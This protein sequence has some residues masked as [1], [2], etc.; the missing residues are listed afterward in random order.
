MDNNQQYLVYGPKQE[1]RIRYE[2]LGKYVYECLTTRKPNEIIAIDALTKTKLTCEE[3]LSKSIKLSI[4]LKKLSIEKGDVIVFL[5][6]NN[7]LYYIALCAS[8][9]CGAQLIFLNPMYKTDELKHAFSISKPKLVFASKT[10]LEIVLSIQKEFDCIQEVVLMN[11]DNTLGVQSIN[12]LIENI[13]SVAGFEI[14]KVDLKDTVFLCL[15]SGTTGLPKCVEMTHENLIPFMNYIR[16]KYYFHLTSKDVAVVVIPF[17]HIYGLLVHLVPTNLFTVVVMKSFKPEVYLQSIEEYKATKL[18]V[19]PPILQFLVNSPMVSK[20]NL[21]S[22]EDIFVGGAAL[23]P[24]LYNEALVKFKHCSI[25]QLYGSTETAGA[26]T[27]Q[28]ADDKFITV[29]KVVM[30]G[31]IKIVDPD[32]KAVLGP[33][34]K[35][36]IRFKSLSVMKGYF[37]N[38]TET[39]NSIDSDGFYCTG[40]IGYYDENKNF[41]IVDRLKELIKYKGFQVSPV[42]VENLLLK[43]P[44]VKDCGVIGIPD[45]RCGQLP[46]A[47]VVRKPNSD[48]TEEELIKFVAEKISI[49]KQLHGGVRFVQELPRTP[50]GKIIRRELMKLYF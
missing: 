39:K 5:S 44:S 29:G 34:E 16:D 30:N 45:D 4:A 48:V 8:L 36:E 22:V 11:N 33:Y 17:F 46:S 14:R 26:C 21:T 43:H 47:L 37:N 20:F 6:E 18:F 24:D 10:V 15:S 2:F 23:S 49:H 19:V 28:H 42:E 7:L 38:P 25:R 50:S 35:G 40:D 32:T 27:V 31:I 3:L 9:Y 13:D 1:Y 12:E 41:Y